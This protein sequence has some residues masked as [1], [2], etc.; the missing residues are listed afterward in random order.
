MATIDVKWA[1]RKPPASYKIMVEHPGII[2][3]EIFH[4]AHQ[5]SYHAYN[6]FML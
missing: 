6:R 4:M 5:Q 1:G 2:S 3:F